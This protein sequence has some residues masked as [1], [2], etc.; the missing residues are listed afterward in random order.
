MTEDEA[1]AQVSDAAAA[2]LAVIRRIRA[3][4]FQTTFSFHGL[5]TENLDIGR[6][7]VMPLEQAENEMRAFWAKFGR[8]QHG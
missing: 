7:C 6:L 3:A 5:G 2:F 4:G 8:N 1:R